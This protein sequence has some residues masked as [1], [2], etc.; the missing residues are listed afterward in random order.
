[1]ILLSWNAALPPRRR[2]VA[3]FGAGLI[4]GSIVRSLVSGQAAEAAILPFSWDAPQDV[5]HDEMAKIASAIL[6]ACPDTTDCRID[7][8]WSAGRAGF[9]GDS[10]TFEREKRSFDGAL[11]LGRRL[12]DAS[13]AYRSRFHLL[14]SAGGL[15]EGQRHVG[16][17]TKPTPLRPYGHA[18][19][20][21]EQAVQAMQPDLDYAIYRPSSVYGYGGI[22]GRVGLMVALIKAALRN[23]TAH[24]Y[25]LQETM[26]DFV[27]ASDIG[28]F[29]ARH[30]THPT[31]ASE[32]FLLA[33]GRP[34][35]MFE[36]V[37]LI[38]SIMGRRLSLQ[39]IR[40]GDN[41]LHNSYLPSAIA[42]NWSPT[43]LEVGIAHTAE[44]MRSQYFQRTGA[45]HH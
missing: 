22:N 42:K 14:S 32:T 19:L 39:F 45:T 7:I 29:I 40:G 23:E 41:A 31:S 1:M 11:D 26:R 16:P 37:S 3:I 18:K 5:Q 34:T 38:E 15:F 4:G 12:A 33:A 36:V 13:S 44:D 24:I 27:L 35:A 9:G 43:S 21:Q 8:V 30:V 6:A 28:H 10:V 20:A 17:D 25:G 2:I